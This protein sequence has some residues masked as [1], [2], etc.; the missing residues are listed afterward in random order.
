MPRVQMLDREALPGWAQQRYH[1]DDEALRVFA[2]TPE[3][4][5]AWLG[6]A[7]VALKSPGRLG[8]RLKELIR[9]KSAFINHCT[10]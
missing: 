10:R 3:L 7:G 6:F 5:E 4:H 2:R 1:P 9:L 8:A